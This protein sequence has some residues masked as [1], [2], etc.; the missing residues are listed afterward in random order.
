LKCILNI[1]LLKNTIIIK[2]K[3]ENGNK[4]AELN[5][6]ERAWVNGGFNS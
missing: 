2:V 3:D 4:L 6:G 5:S 1:V